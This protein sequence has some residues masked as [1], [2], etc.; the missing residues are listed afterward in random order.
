MIK[1]FAFGGKCSAVDN[2]QSTIASPDLANR[3]QRNWELRH[4]IR[5][6]VS[7]PDATAAKQKPFRVPERLD[8]SCRRLL[9]FGRTMLCLIGVGPCTWTYA[10]FVLWTF[11]KTPFGKL[12]AS[13]DSIVSP[14]LLHALWQAVV[15]AE[16]PDIS[17]TTMYHWTDVNSLRVKV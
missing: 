17:I 3:R 13:P 1:N 11:H 4:L 7:A 16:S 8:F 14:V 12:V 6:L 9:A 5:R 15:A 2:R 10:I